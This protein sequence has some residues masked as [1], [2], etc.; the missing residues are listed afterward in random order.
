[1]IADGALARHVEQR[2]AGWDGKLGKSI[3]AGK[4][5]LA[6]LAA[7]VDK[8]ALEPQPRS[9]RQERLEALVNTYF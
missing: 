7:L 5:S 4:Q 3:L 8:S 9:G 2:Y 1:M 6:E